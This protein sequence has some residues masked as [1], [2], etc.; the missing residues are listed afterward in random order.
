[1]N[2]FELKFKIPAQSL[3]KIV[4]AVHA[5]KAQLQLLQACYFDTEDG[6]LAKNGL[7]LRMRKEGNV[8][9]QTAKQLTNNALER[10]EHN[11]EIGRIQTNAVKTNAVKINAVNIKVL[12]YKTA[13]KL[14]NL[15]PSIDLYRHADE[16]IGKLI[17]CALKVKLN[18]AIPTLVLLY[19]TDV[20]RL[21]FNVKHAGSLIEIAL[22]Q[23]MVISGGRSAALCELE[24]ELKQG[25]PEHAVALARTWCAK[26]GLWLS[27][28]NK[29]MEGQRL[30]DGLSS[31]QKK[32]KSVAGKPDLKSDANSQQMVKAVFQSC[33]NEILAN[34]SE[35]GAGKPF[36]G[37]N[38]NQYA[39][40]IHQ[41]RVG[42]RRLR[43]AMRELNILV[44]GIDPAWEKPLIDTFR[45]LGE[46]RDNDY[47]NLILQPQIVAAGGPAISTHVDVAKRLD[48]SAVVRSKA[49]QDTLLCLIA[50]VNSRYLDGL[51][52]TDAENVAENATEN[53]SHKKVRNLLAN[54]LN[55]L[56]EKIVKEGKKFLSLTGTQQHSVRKHFKRLRYLA[57]FSAPHFSMLEKKRTLV[58]ITALKPVQDALGFYNDELVGLQTYRKLVATD[59]RA[60]FGAGWLSARRKSNAKKCQQQIDIFIKKTKKNKSKLRTTKI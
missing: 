50:Y 11:V 46:H 26:Y 60:W 35:I 30:H 22:D 34:A 57:E 7:T 15:M 37:D 19:K 52:P 28:I 25:A 41:M 18:R 23:G 54:R 42:I 21:K 36:N 13:N 53:Y 2:E 45:A 17:M 12:D 8:W 44:D 5:K 47:L 40:H 56:H 16:K 27:I 43:T 10:L 38:H 24:I 55:K 49:F 1:M 6:A 51:S 3:P 39:E 58:F 31:S 33:L 14:T 20:Q 48:A 29:S 32:Q 4:A 9:V 59:K